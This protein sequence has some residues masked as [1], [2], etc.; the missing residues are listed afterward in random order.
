MRFFGDI[1]DF[2]GTLGPPTAFQPQWAGVGYKS[3]LF[4]SSPVGH[5]ITPDGQRH[6]LINVHPED[7]H[8]PV[9]RALLGYIRETGYNPYQ[10]DIPEHQTYWDSLSE[11]FGFP[12]SRPASLADQ[13]LPADTL[14]QAS[15]DLNPATGRFPRLRDASEA[16]LPRKRGF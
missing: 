16:S 1:N 6:Q 11:Q 13:P 7:A 5:V 8:L 4:E 2:L 3:Y 10:F 15:G 14:P 9:E 12:D